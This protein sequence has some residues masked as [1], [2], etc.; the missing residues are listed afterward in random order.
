MTGSTQVRF[1]EAPHLTPSTSPSLSARFVPLS[2][3]T[4]GISSTLPLTATYLGGYDVIVMASYV[5][6]F[7]NIRLCDLSGLGDVESHVLVVVRGPPSAPKGS[8]SLD[9]GIL[10]N[11]GNQ[12]HHRKY[13]PSRRQSTRLQ[14]WHISPTT[15]T[16]WVAYNNMA[17]LQ[18]KQNYANAHCVGGTFVWDL[19][20]TNGQFSTA[21]LQLQLSLPGT[22]AYYRAQAIPPTTE[23]ITAVQLWLDTGPVWIILYD[24]EVFFVCEFAI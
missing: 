11:R 18:M 14:R 8:C 3:N 20:Q 6:F 23:R 5:D 9:A 24:I 17:T 12:K 13:K 22:G 4:Y 19:T 15:T 16:R 10:M 21:N 2:V 7:F 1:T